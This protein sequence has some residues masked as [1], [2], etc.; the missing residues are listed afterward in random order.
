MIALDTRSTFQSRSEADR[1]IA[2]L[3]EWAGK[4]L[5]AFSRSYP[6]CSSVGSADEDA[7]LAGVFALIASEWPFHSPSHF[8]GL[9]AGIIGVHERRFQQLVDIS[10]IVNKGPMQRRTWSETKPYQQ[11]LAV[12]STWADAIY[13]EMLGSMWRP[14]VLNPEMENLNAAEDRTRC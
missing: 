10:R 6:P 3:Q 11:M 2:S 5:T 8:L 12:L 1:F 7:I 14:P 9:L 4:P 13:D